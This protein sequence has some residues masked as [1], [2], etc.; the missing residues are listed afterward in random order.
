MI[1]NLPGVYRFFNDKNELIYIGKAKNLRRRLAQ[2]R[3]AKRRKAH[4]KMRKI[5]KEGVRLEHEVCDTE[6]DALIL[7]NQLI[8]K[9]RPKW[10][11]AGAF[12][13]LYP[14]IGIRI[15]K[16]GHLFFCYTTTPEK[17]P[18][19]EFHGAFRSRARTR[20]SF[21]ALM[22]LLRMIGHP[23]PR[24]QLRKESVLGE[25]QKFE[26]VYGFRQIPS[27]WLPDVNLFF[28][29]ESFK[30]IEKLSLML[31]EKP[32]ARAR[33]S[34]TQDQLRE[35]RQFWRHEILRLKKAREVTHWPSYPISQQDRDLL[36]ITANATLT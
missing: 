4:A 18:L 16:E 1:P 23:I 11:V 3:N 15:N 22:A 34:E 27:D 10:N 32:S 24:S 20:E 30:A 13:F 9:H 33:S 19:F 21:F 26:Y 31:L 36:L 29:G 6:L 7:E 12:F 17:H 14:M 5:F 25:P 2:Y 35:L 28:S 8:Q